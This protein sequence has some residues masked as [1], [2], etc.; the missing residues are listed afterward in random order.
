MCRR[1]NCC[2]AV[3]GG[4]SQDCRRGTVRRYLVGFSLFV[5][6]VIFHCYENSCFIFFILF[7]FWFYFCFVSSYVSNLAQFF[8]RHASIK[9]TFSRHCLCSLNQTTSL[10]VYIC[11]HTPSL[12]FSFQ[13]SRNNITV[14]STHRNHSTTIY[15]CTQ[16]C[17]RHPSSY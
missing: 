4:L 9:S 8:L 10:C 12:F 16:L 13:K 2:K 6:S 1:G 17:S 15:H 3:A 7:V 5:F 14:L 11:N